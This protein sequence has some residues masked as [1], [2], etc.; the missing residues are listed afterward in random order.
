MDYNKVEDAVL[1]KAMDIFRQSAVSF[2]NIG[3]RIIAPAETEIK[4]IEIKTGYTDYLFYTEDGSYLHFE[5]QTTDKK[6]DIKRFLYYDASLFYRE[7]RKVR[8]IVVYSSDIEDVDEYIDAGTIKYRI[9]PFYMKNIDG[10]ERIEYLKNKIHNGEKLTYNDILCITFLPLMSGSESRSE[11]A[12]KSIELAQSIEDNG[13]KLECTSMLY[14]LLDK[15]GDEISRRKLKEMINMTEIGKM[16]RDEGR[17][18]GRKEGKSELIIKQLIKK[19]KKLP[20]G[21]TDK[22]NSLSDETLDVI[23]T[24]IFNMEKVEELERYF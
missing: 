14:A 15:F 10:D 6:D 8:T 21:Y 17:K 7:K 5:F 13:T 20:V 1:K 12:V 3:T 24:D 23:A 16:I 9:E 11:R 4:N 2:F 19:F 18:E 22:I